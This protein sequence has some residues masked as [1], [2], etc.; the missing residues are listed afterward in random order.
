MNKTVKNS[1][2]D[3]GNTNESDILKPLIFLIKKEIIFGFLFILAGLMLLFQKLL[4]INLDV[5]GIISAVFFVM[6]V[7]FHLKFFQNKEF[8]KFFL[9]G[10]IFL[11]LALTLSEHLVPIGV[12]KI[13]VLFILFQI[14]A[15]S[16]L[17]YTIRNDI[18]WLIVLCLLPIILI[19]I[20]LLSP[21]AP[22]RIQGSAAIWSIAY[23]FFY[24]SF[25]K[26]AK[27]RIFLFLSGL[28]FLIGF[29]N[30]SSQ[31]ENFLS[32]LFLWFLGFAFLV[33]YIQN[34]KIWWPLIPSYIFMWSGF[35]VLNDSV[36][37]FFPENWMAFFWTAGFAAMFLLIW[38]LTK[39]K[40]PQKWSLWISVI[41]AFISVIIL[42]T[43]ILKL[44]G[45]IVIPSILIIIGIWLI[46]SKALKQTRV[47]RKS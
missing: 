29:A 18:P 8:F 7:W 30:T 5:V 39:N 32:V 41:F 17:A 25:V 33:Y 43:D 14:A 40:K 44:E 10:Q 46:Y 26:P 45:E 23:A 42:I 24:I 9:L 35:N 4:D 6:G 19:V 47:S 3:K 31:S 16:A 22:L 38:I 13:F 34:T 20:Y 15:V 37:R 12:E 11:L 1:K 28:F 21:E 2:P 27:S 36:I